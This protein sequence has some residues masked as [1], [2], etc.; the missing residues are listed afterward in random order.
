MPG[1]KRY[2]R[3]EVTGRIRR[4]ELTAR[5]VVEGFLSGMHRSPYFGQS[6]EFLQHRQYVPGD[7]IRHIDWKVYARQD[8]LHIKQYEE[9]T[10]LRLQLVVD[11]SASMAYGDGDSNKFDYSASIAASLAY[12]ALRQKDAT[13]L[14]TFD[15]AVRDSITARSNQQQLAR[16]L[17]LLESVGADGRTD[18]K[19]VAME[20]AQTIPR[21]GLVV[22]ISD[23]LGVDSLLEG[24][25]VFRARGHDVALFHVLHDHEVDFQFDGATRFE[26]LETDQILNCNP[27][28]LREGYLEALNE[29]L[30]STRRACGRLQIDYMLTRTSEPLDAVLAKFLSTRLRLPNLRK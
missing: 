12:L 3:P 22:V 5:R 2:L 6:I 21:R 9:E 24:L 18:L 20:I 27:R 13:G 26:G 16:M 25:Q 8:R 7:E 19:S 30:E 1:S 14:Y 11:R 28:A 15:T 10:N 29:F 23:L 4:L 17:A